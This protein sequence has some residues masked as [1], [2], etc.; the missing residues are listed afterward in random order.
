MTRWFAGAQLFVGDYQARAV[1]I[2]DTDPATALPAQANLVPGAYDFIVR[3]PV[4][5]TPAS[6]SSPSSQAGP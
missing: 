5:G 1:P 2:A 4:V 3:H 6:T